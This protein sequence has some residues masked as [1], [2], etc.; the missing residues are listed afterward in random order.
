MTDYLVEIAAMTVECPCLSYRWA[1]GGMRAEEDTCVKCWHSDSHASNCLVVS[2]KDERVLDPR[3]KGLRKDCD[4][5][6]HVPAHSHYMVWPSENTLTY[7]DGGYTDPPAGPLCEGYTINRDLGV[8]LECI[9]GKW[10]LLTPRANSDAKYI[11]AI[12][13]PNVE[14]NGDTTLETASHALHEWLQKQE[15][16]TT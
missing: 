10:I 1:P 5:I 12:E 6:K 14:A 15:V 11:C 4:V 2:C 8:L 7:T 9:P 16:R 13:S 3:F